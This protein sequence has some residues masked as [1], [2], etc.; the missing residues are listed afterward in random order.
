MTDFIRRKWQGLNGNARISIVLLLA[1]IGSTCLYAAHSRI[2]HAKGKKG[3]KLDIQTVKGSSSYVQIWA[4]T[5]LMDEWKVVALD[6]GQDNGQSWLDANDDASRFYKVVEIPIDAPADSDGDGMDDVFEMRHPHLDPLD[7]KDA[8]K[9]C[10]EDGMLNIQEYHAEKSKGNQKIILDAITVMPVASPTETAFSV[11][12]Q[13]RV[14]PTDAHV[15]AARGRNDK[16]YYVRQILEVFSSAGEKVRTITQDFLIDPTGIKNASEYVAITGSSVWNG[17][18]DSGMPVPDDVYT[19][20]IHAQY[21]RV[22]KKVKI[23]DIIK[24]PGAK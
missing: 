23:I 13:Y 15:G 4:T 19:I 17:R 20:R 10:D 24:P 18:D 7:G 5:S 9:D 2:E 11:Y 12:S 6:W 14:R 1:V 3:F 16:S 8:K 22:A 21:I